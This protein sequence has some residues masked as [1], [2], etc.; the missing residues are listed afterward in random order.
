MDLHKLPGLDLTSA[1]LIT[2]SQ[3][4]AFAANRKTGVTNGTPASDHEALL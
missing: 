4:L 2:I 1:P 3:P